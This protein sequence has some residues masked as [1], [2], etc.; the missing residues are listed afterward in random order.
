[1]T[2]S[3]YL[4]MQGMTDDPKNNYLFTI[5]NSLWIKDLFLSILEL[6][7]EFMRIWT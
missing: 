6:R 3:K 4:I 7:R 5:S 2:L 1:M